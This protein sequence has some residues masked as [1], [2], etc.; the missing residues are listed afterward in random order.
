MKYIFF[1]LIGLVGGILG[2][3]GMGGG[4][5]T[6]PMLTF[7]TG[8]SQRAAQGANLIAFIPMSIVALFI[9]IKNKLVDKSAVLPILIPAVLTAVLG[10]VLSLETRAEALR[11]YFGIFLIVLGAVHLVVFAVK[12]IKKNKENKEK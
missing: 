12:K 7:F 3:M 2:G 11:K 6:I 8:V 10:A 5:L 4:T 9:H 1:I